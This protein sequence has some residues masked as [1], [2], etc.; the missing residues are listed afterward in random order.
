MKERTAENNP[1]HDE[2]EGEMED[3]DGKMEGKYEEEVKIEEEEGGEVKEN[4]EDKE[5]GGKQ[6]KEEGSQGVAD[7]EW[8]NVGWG[9]DGDN[10]EK[11]ATTD[12]VAGQVDE[13]Q[14]D[15][16]QLDYIY[17]DL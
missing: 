11:T 1:D 13:G 15:Q 5:D 2:K 6:G 8:G 4:G 7:E 9:D 12:A 3:D 16:E 17:D 14:N 10:A